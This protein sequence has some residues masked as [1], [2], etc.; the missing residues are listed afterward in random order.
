M[1]YTSPSGFL[2]YAN[3]FV[4]G[5]EPRRIQPEWLDDSLLERDLVTSARTRAR[6]MPPMPVE[7]PT[8]APAPDHV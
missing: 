6:M 4:R 8:P 2:S 5:L 3:E 7:E 1:E